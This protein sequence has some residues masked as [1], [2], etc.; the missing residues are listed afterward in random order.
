MLRCYGGY[1]NPRNT[2]TPVTPFRVRFSAQGLWGYGMW[3]S[4]NNTFKNH[5]EN[6]TFTTYIDLNEKPTYSFC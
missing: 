2:V 4:A 1:G 5:D 3:G 6:H